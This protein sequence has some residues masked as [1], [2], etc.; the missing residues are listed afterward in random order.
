VGQAAH[1]EIHHPDGNGKN[2]EKHD[3]EGREKYFQQ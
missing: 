1:P 3:P 2:A